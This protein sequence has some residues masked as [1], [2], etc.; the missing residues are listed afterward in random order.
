[1]AH[2]YAM[3]KEVKQR[4][5]GRTDILL[6]SDEHASYKPAIESAY[7]AEEQRPQQRSSK[8]AKRTMPKNL[9]YATVR[10]ERSNACHVRRPC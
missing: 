1:M 6:T 7:A 8:K 9:C 3:V 10:K 2:C 4:T 5:G